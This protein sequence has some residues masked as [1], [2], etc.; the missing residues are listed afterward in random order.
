MKK[1]RKMKVLAPSSRLQ[2]SLGPWAL[3][4][5]Q[6]LRA[7]ETMKKLRKTMVLAPSG[8]RA[9]PTPKPWKT[10]ENAMFLEVLESWN[11]GTPESRSRSRSPG[12]LESLG[13]RE[14]WSRS[15]S[16]GIPE[17]ILESRSPRAEALNA[18][19]AS[20]PLPNTKNFRNKDFNSKTIRF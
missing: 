4:G 14:S 16:P 7:T 18:H 9:G 12:V 11:P 17:S 1:Q 2:A 3:P 13:G 19:P 20:L 8:R 5:A 6:A 15:R 10:F